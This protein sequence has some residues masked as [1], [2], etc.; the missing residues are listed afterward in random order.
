MEKSPWGSTVP[1]TK[2]LYSSLHSDGGVRLIQNCCNGELKFLKIGY[3]STNGEI[4]NRIKRNRNIIRIKLNA[5]SIIS[6]P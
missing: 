4:I 2:D 1:Q 6:F 3:K 5:K